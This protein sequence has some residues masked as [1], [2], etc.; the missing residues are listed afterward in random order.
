ML[1]DRALRADLG[2]VP[3]VAVEERR[4][5]HERGQQDVAS[6][7]LLSLGPRPEAIARGLARL[8]SGPV[9]SQDL[10]G[11]ILQAHALLA[12]AGP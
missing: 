4:R 5:G 3:V 8:R 1:K 11:A 10:A 6:A 2:E 7:L 12:S 9:S